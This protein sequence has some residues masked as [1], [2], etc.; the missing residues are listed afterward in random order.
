MREVMEYQ[1]ET[2]KKQLL[3]LQGIF[4]FNIKYIDS[5]NY[6]DNAMN[7]VLAMKKV[8][9]EIAQIEYYLQLK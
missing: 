1:L 4:K 6:E 2:K 9:T 3:E 7:A 5:P 8:K